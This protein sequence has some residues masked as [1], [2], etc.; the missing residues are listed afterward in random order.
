MGNNDD[1][2]GV[3][4]LAGRGTKWV[5]Q[6]SQPEIGSVGR[7]RIMSD[8]VGHIRARCVKPN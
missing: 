2:G 5:S 6:I 8:L 3:R 4:E 7:D 1:T